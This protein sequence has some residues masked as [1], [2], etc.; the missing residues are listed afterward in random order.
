MEALN[1]LPPYILPIAVLFIFL[2]FFYG[3]DVSGLVK[4]KN[5]VTDMISSI[6]PSV[7]IGAAKI[8]GEK[9]TIPEEQRVAIEYLK[10]TISKMKTS[11]NIGVNGCFANYNPSFILRS[12]ENQK[13]G[14]PPLK[15]TSLLLEK[16]PE[17]MRLIIKNDLTEV[18]TEIIPG[19]NPCVVSGRDSTGIIP[20]NFHEKIIQG[21]DTVGNTFLPVTEI[22]ILD[23]GTK[24]AYNRGANIDLEDGGFLYTPDG[25]HI[26]FFPTKDFGIDCSPSDNEDGLNDDCLGE[27]DYKVKVT[28]KYGESISSLLGA[29]KL[30]WC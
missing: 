6:T 14:F 16:N 26:C 3:S 21:K 4:V 19:V 24:I 15:D 9:P 27:G 20:A 23:G 29:K 25:S 5:F 18:S 8:P 1:K 17:G 11:A 22:N 28:A 2:Y 10:T 7:N 30:S 13:Q 12:N